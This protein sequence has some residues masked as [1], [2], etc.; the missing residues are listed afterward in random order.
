MSKIKSAL[1]ISLIATTLGFAS[2]AKAEQLKIALIEALSGPAAQTGRMYAEPMEFAIKEINAGGGYNGDKVVLLT[3]DNEGTP[4]G[5]SNKL[6]SAVADGA[7]IIFQSASSLVA[8]QLTDDVRK[9]N[10]RNPGREI[11]YINTGSEAYELTGEKCQFWFI[12]LSSNAYMRMN[13]LTAVMKEKN[14]LG[15]G[16]YSINQ[17]YSYGQDGQKA[18]DQ[19]VTAQGAKVV[20]TDLIDV[21]KVQDFSPY[22]AKIKSSGADT[23]LTTNWANDLIL[24]LRA[25]H[26]AGLKARFG[27]TAL[28]V[29]G[30]LSA[31]GH[32]ALGYYFSTLY[33]LDA[34][35]QAQ[36]T[37]AA[38][39]KSATGSYPTY[40]RPQVVFA[41]RLLAEALKKSDFG[42]GPI[43]INKI[44][45]SL[46]DSQVMTPLGKWSIRKAD[47][48][49]VMPVAVTEISTDVKYTIDGTDMGL[50]PIAVI[51]G[52]KAVVPVDAACKMQRPQ[53]Y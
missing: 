5:A 18:I 40:F 2:G 20:G 36:D 29:P 6:K 48:Q 21:L 33:T 12:K 42:G 16:V 31:A 32:I 34:G 4:I 39:Y 3:Y 25:A 30:A 50:K 51:E 23:V 9:Y 28:D 14:V 43:N 45:V 27:V 35:G 11:L 17:N 26:S 49:G 8:G 22:V 38:E 24:L 47:H 15:K 52:E 19:Y 53:G 1:S 44:V 41:V 37:L 10:L 7:R 13:A 46:E